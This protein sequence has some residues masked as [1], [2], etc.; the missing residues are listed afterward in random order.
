MREPGSGSETP[1]LFHSLPLPPPSAPTALSSQALKL[2]T[3]LWTPPTPS[4]DSGPRATRGLHTLCPSGLH[5]PICTPQLWA[6]LLCH[7]Q[8]V[9]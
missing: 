1:D 6:L 4:L 2:Q 7:P 3:M 8:T 5:F 9:V